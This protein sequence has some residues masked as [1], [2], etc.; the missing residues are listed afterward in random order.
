MVVTLTVVSPGRAD[1]WIGCLPRYD[2]ET[3]RI[4]TLCY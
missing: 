2:P 4:Y 1:A 3:G